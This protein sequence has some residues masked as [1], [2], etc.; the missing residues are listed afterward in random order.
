[1]LVSCDVRGLEVVTAA[2]IS[3][4]VVLQ[5]EIKSGIDLHSRNQE[6]LKLP[7]RLIA[8]VFMFR[9]I[10]GGSAYGFMKDP[11]FADLKYNEKQW[12]KVIDSFYEK[13]SGLRKWHAKLT[14]DILATGFYTSPSGRQYNYKKLI[15]EYSEYYYLPK[16]K[17]YPIQGFGADIV[18]LARIILFRRMKRNH[19]KALLVNTIHDSIIIDT[20]QDEVETLV[21]LITDIFVE[22]PAA[23]NKTFDIDFNLP[24]GVEFK[25]LN[26]EPI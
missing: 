7:S 26:G 18:M 11:D 17:N 4:D 24:L 25:Q 23:L 21:K 12:N 20:P 3:G 10:Y 8:K 5:S 22:L 9:M 6:D 19:M 15:A 13:Y 1:M 14:R 2:Y 16:F